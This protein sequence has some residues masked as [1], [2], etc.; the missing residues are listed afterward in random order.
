MVRRREYALMQAYAEGFDVFPRMPARRE[1][2]GIYRYDLGWQT[3]PKSG[4]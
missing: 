1:L 3:V 4:I 2:S